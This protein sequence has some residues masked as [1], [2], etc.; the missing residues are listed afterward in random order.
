M[1]KMLKRIDNKTVRGSSFVVSVPDI[2]RVIYTEGEKVA[3][4]GIEG[5]MCVG[6]RVEWVVYSKTLQGWE[7]PHHYD[8]MT[9]SKREEI[10]ADVSKSL[11]LLEM[12]HTLA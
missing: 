6:G 2:H 1:D 12:P 7:Q 8:E 5:G 11:A 4:V 3:S 10:L 9:P